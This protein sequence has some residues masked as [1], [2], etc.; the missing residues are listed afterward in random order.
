VAQQSSNTL[1]FGLGMLIIL[2]SVTQGIKSLMTALNNCYN[3]TEERGFIKFNTRAFLLALG[4][5]LLVVALALVVAVLAQLGESGRRGYRANECFTGTLAHPCG[6]CRRGA[7]NDVSLR[8]LP[9]IV[10]VELGQPGLGL[11]H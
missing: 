5:I 7:R 9:K 2:W 10:R 1:S 6:S 8:S 3:E 11:R 4:T